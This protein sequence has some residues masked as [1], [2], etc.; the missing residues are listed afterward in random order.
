MDPPVIPSDIPSP[1]PP[2]SFLP[3]SILDRDARLLGKLLRHLWSC[4]GLCHGERLVL[5]AVFQHMPL[6]DT[7]NNL[8]NL[9]DPDL[10]EAPLPL[11]SPSPVNK[12]PRDD[13][14]S[15]LYDRILRLPVEQL[16]LMAKLFT[17]A[18]AGARSWGGTQKS[19]PGTSSTPTPLSSLGLSDPIV[20]YDSLFSTLQIQPFPDMASAADRDDPS[21]RGKGKV[22]HRPAYQKR[23]CFDRQLHSCAITGGQSNLQHAHIIPHSIVSLSGADGGTATIFWMALAIIL[24]PSLRDTA[25]SIVGAGENFYDTTNSIALVSGLHG[26][27]DTGQL[28]LVPEVTEVFDVATS[29]HLDVRIC[30][31]GS[32][33]DLA[34]IS[35][36]R[37]SSPDEQVR[38]LENTRSYAPPV[39]PTRPVADGDRFRLF[40]N[41]PE[42][43]PLP[44]PLLLGIHTMLWRMI[45][46]AG[47]AETSHTRKRRHVDAVDGDAV[48]GAGSK[49]A[50]RGS[51]GGR[52]RAGGR[53][54]RSARSHRGGKAE[55]SLGGDEIAPTPG[56]TSGA[57][58]VDA[59]DGFDQ[60]E[61][62]SQCAGH[63]YSDNSRCSTDSDTRTLNE[64]T[65]PSGALASRT[66]HE[67]VPLNNLQLAWIRFRLKFGAS[68]HDSS[69]YESHSGSSSDETSDR[70][71]EYGSDEYDGG[72]ESEY[73][74]GGERES[75]HEA[76]QARWREAVASRTGEAWKARMEVAAAEK[77]VDGGCS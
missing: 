5:G 72:V 23:A 65:P 39:L 49:R 47:M 15:S 27:L 1:I 53:R 8:E 13:Q 32:L 59:V 40:T 26:H 29:R 55:S 22:T 36:A 31:L 60:F 30:W 37:P 68:R 2:I 12:N 14:H 16:K 35:T 9:S 71:G 73:E 69:E 58:A 63:Y 20:G 77:S 61:W 38:V 24:G 45:A 18:L 54:G 52:R 17:A 67:P 33:L 28:H 74:D 43:H 70:D 56:G 3:P 19:E 44:H 62:H 6:I 76:A 51:G 41:N 11:I 42:K 34:L 10:D 50:R 48:D 64:M 7:D 75:A 21:T 57:A 25:F 4:P 46:T 66:P